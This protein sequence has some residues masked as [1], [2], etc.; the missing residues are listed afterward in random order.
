MELNKLEELALEYISTQLEPIDYQL[1]YS[2][3]FEENALNFDKLSVK[4]WL[5]LYC[6]PDILIIANEQFDEYLRYNYSLKWK[7]TVNS[8]Y[9]VDVTEFP[10]THLQDH[11]GKTKLTCS[12]SFRVK[13][14]NLALYEQVVKSNDRFRILMSIASKRYSG[15]WQSDLVED[16]QISPKDLFS[17]LTCLCK[18]GLVYKLTIPQNSLYKYLIDSINEN[19]DFKYDTNE[20]AQQTD[21]DSSIK[22]S[23]SICFFHKFFVI[24]K[25]PDNIKALCFSDVKNNCESTMLELLEKAQNNIMLESDWRRAYFNTAFGELNQYNIRADNNAITKSYMSLRKTLESKNKITLIFAWCP[26]TKKYERSIMLLK[27]QKDNILTLKRTS[28]VH[29]INMKTEHSEEEHV[30]EYAYYMIKTAPDGISAK[31]INDHVPSKYKSMLKTL[32]I[33][34]DLGLIRKQTHRDGKKFMYK[35]YSNDSRRTMIKTEDLSDASCRSSSTHYEMGDVKLENSQAETPVN[36]D[37]ENAGLYGTK[38]IDFINAHKIKYYDDSV[39]LREYENRFGGMYLQSKLN[40]TLFKKRMVMMNEYLENFKAATQTN[41]SKFISEIEGRGT[42]PDRKS[43]FRILEN[44]QKKLTHFKLLCS[45]EIKQTNMPLTVIY[46][47]RHFTDVE[48]YSFLKN[49]INEKRILICS[50][51]AQLKSKINDHFKNPEHVNNIT[52]DPVEIMY[53]ESSNVGNLKMPLLVKDVSVNQQNSTARMEEGM[54]FSQRRQSLNGYVFPVMTRV[55]MLHGLLID[56]FKSETFTTSELLREMTL[57]HYYQMIG[58]GY[59]IPN[60]GE[61]MNERIENLPQEHVK[62]LM[63]KKRDPINILNNQ[64]NFLYRIKLV[65]FSSEMESSKTSNEVRCIEDNHNPSIWNNVVWPKSE[66]KWKIIRYVHLYDFVNN[67]K[68]QRYDMFKEHQ[69]FWNNFKAQV[70]EYVSTGNG[71]VPELLPVKEVFSKKNW[72]KA[73]YLNTIVKSELD[74]VIALWMEMCCS[75]LHVKSLSKLCCIPNKVLRVLCDRFTLTKTQIQ[76]HVKSKVRSSSC[77]SQDEDDKILNKILS[78]MYKGTELLWISRYV[79]AE[80]I[81]NRIFLN[82]LR[83]NPHTLPRIDE[84][85]EY[86]RMDMIDLGTIGISE[87]CADGSSIKN[88][89]FLPNVWKYLHIL[90]NYKYSVNE[91]KA[92][93]DYIINN[94]SLNLRVLNKLRRLNTSEIISYI[95][96]KSYSNIANSYNTSPSSPKVIPKLN[97]DEPR[98][99]ENQIEYLSNKLKLK[100]TMFTSSSKRLGAAVSVHQDIKYHKKILKTWCEYGWLVRCSKKSMILKV[101]KLSTMSK[102]KLFPKYTNIN[103]FANQLLSYIELNNHDDFNSIDR[104]YRNNGAVNE[105]VMGGQGEFGLVS[106]YKRM[107]IIRNCLDLDIHNLYNIVENLGEIG[108]DI[109]WTFHPQ[110]VDQPKYFRLM[111]GGISKH[112]KALT[113][114]I[115]VSQVKA[116]ITDLQEKLNT[117]QYKR[118]PDTLRPVPKSYVCDHAGTDIIDPVV[119][120]NDPL[121]SSRLVNDG[122]QDDHTKKN[123]N[124]ISDVLVYVMKIYEADYTLKDMEKGFHKLVKAVKSK[125]VHGIRHRELITTMGNCKLNNING[126]YL[127]ARDLK[128]NDDYMTVGVNNMLY[129]IL[130]SSALIL[131]LMFMIPNGQEFIYLYWLHSDKI[132]INSPCFCYKNSTLPASNVTNESIEN[133]QRTRPDYIS[134]ILWLMFQKNALQI[135]QDLKDFTSLIRDVIEDDIEGYRNALGSSVYSPFTV[136]DGCFNVHMV[137]FISLKIYS[138]VKEKPGLTVHEL[139][140]EMAILDE[141]E[142]ELLVDSMIL[143]KILLSKEINVESEPNHLFSSNKKTDCVKTVLYPQETCAALINFKSILLVR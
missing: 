98:P 131:R 44:L 17:V 129:K 23:A 42:R 49:D 108:F 53:P 8:L 99:L 128:N 137:A 2:R 135:P 105:Y 57:E 54:V 126:D 13:K 15:Y 73:M 70:D 19:F 76:M 141:C 80:K 46:D 3:I 103:F 118:G 124:T 16:L 4:L 30:E 133:G 121:D 143:R 140:N 11:I 74:R 107:S 24:D 96:K 91:C 68:K 56:K 94:S 122:I 86:C 18:L 45:D 47:S 22:N 55:K 1:L 89:D 14:L 65:S 28:M 115:G 51:S 92:I 59:Q 12:N 114:S 75:G 102:M 87:H 123:M 84:L 83:K 82:I 97:G 77:E 71:S 113:S 139:W 69:E 10:E 5:R 66:L 111:D 48:A 79:I 88:G 36:E 101:Y 21:K 142:V 109:K 95:S 7:T 9:D 20:G 40:T 81:M 136:L 60:V 43:V 134:E 130:I 93:F 67:E 138:I 31:E 26:Q 72:K 33:M 132:I 25:I 35:Y 34:E 29:V 63:N 27:N 100:C 117:Q 106:N 104:Q 6:N 119:F 64:L 58:C 125:G 62:V 110:K 41:V 127:N 37:T 61:Y 50:K 78:N 52:D 38:Y 116:N 85:E 32:S 120:C 112:I 39:Y 90:F